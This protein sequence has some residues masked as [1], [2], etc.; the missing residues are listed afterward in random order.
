MD[1]THTPQCLAPK[2]C[3]PSVDLDCLNQ[4]MLVASGSSLQSS[5]GLLLH[6]VATG[7]MQTLDMTKRFAGHVL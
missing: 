1:W 5:L 3:I 2:N 7:E 4:E 6:G